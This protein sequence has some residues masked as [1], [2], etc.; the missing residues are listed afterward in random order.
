M[1]P[2]ERTRKVGSFI[3]NRLDDQ[4]NDRVR[5]KHRGLRMAHA[6]EYILRLNSSRTIE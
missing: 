3:A 6:Q 4:R 2:V 5:G 1:E